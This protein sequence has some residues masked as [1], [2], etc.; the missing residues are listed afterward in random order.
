MKSL[1]A[2]MTK[3]PATMTKRDLPHSTPLTLPACAAGCCRRRPREQAAAAGG[4]AAPSAAP[5]AKRAG[6][7]ADRAEAPTRPDLP[8]H[9]DVCV[10]G[11][12]GRA[13][14]W[15]GSTPQPHISLMQLASGR[16]VLPSHAYPIIG[17]RTRAHSHLAGDYCIR[18]GSILQPCT[19]WP[20]R[21]L[22]P[23]H[24]KQHATN[25]QQ[26]TTDISRHTA[27][28]LQTKRSNGR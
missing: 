8:S 19:M 10:R 25:N 5:P 22:K 15:P 9:P 2:T 18:P 28:K 24:T 6:Q 26:A 12:N 17:I 3:L 23:M 7:P 20:R 11:S 14:R 16:G 4:G 21:S 13:R 1:A 27:D